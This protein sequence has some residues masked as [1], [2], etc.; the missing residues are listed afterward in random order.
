MI[1]VKN[2]LLLCYIDFSDTFVFI[3]IFFHLL[4]II[5][6][7]LFINFF[8]KSLLATTEKIILFLKNLNANSYS[9]KTTLHHYQ[10]GQRCFSSLESKTETQKQK[11]FPRVFSKRVVV[12][13]KPQTYTVII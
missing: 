11:R 4:L 7:F 10:T 8:A 5:F 9:V 12:F 6:N 1:I 13:G 3:I 2:Y